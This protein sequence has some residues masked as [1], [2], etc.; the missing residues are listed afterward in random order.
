ME[1]IPFYD[2]GQLDGLLAKS[3][4]RPQVV[5]KH[6]TRCGTS[7]MVKG[8][9][10]RQQ[11]QRALAADFYLLTVI[12]HRAASNYLAERLAVPH[13]SPQLV[14]LV[15]GEVV[16]DQSHLDVSLDEVAEVLGQ[17]S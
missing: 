4:D 9:L 6:S 12:E 15:G 5:L 11:G 3:A 10:E 17:H 13:E 14:V 7:A 2:P 16:L 8:R 1:W